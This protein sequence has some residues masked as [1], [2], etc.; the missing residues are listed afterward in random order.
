MEE[1]DCWL[2]GENFTPKTV[3]IFGGANGDETC[4]ACFSCL[5][6]RADFGPMRRAWPTWEQYQQQVEWHPDPMFK[7]DEESERAEHLGLYASFEKA[8]ELS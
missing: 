8:S 7:T 5:T 6:L 3:I 2:C 1:T 4:E